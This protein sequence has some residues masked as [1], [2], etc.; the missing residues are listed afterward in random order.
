MT[1]RWIALVAAALLLGCATV[2]TKFRTSNSYFAGPKDGDKRCKEK[3]DCPDNKIDPSCFLWACG[4]SLSFDPLYLAKGGH[5]I[6]W[7]L[8]PDYG[9]C[10]QLGDGVFLKDETSD[11]FKLED[12]KEGCQRTFTIHADNK[13]PRPDKPYKYKVVFH[14]VDKDKIPDETPYVIDP[15]MINE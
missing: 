2:D 14:H 1:G 6:T 15:S 11:Q 5:K 7:V 8:P 3:E 10:R 12:Y 9:F 13:T 4:G